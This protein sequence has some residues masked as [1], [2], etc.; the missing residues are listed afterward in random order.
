[1]SLLDALILILVLVVVLVVVQ[2]FASRLSEPY[3]IIL[4]VAVLII[5]IAVLVTLNGGRFPLTGGFDGYAAIN[6]ASYQT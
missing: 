3:R 1:M 5:F 4:F 6:A 2:Y